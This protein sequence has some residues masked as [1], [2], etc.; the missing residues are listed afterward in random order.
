[1]SG[2]EARARA[3]A[4]DRAGFE[5]T[6][7]RAASRYDRTQ[8]GDAPGWAYWMPDP[9]DLAETGRALTMVGRP[10]QAIEALTPKVEAMAEYPRDVVLT[11]AY[12][13]EAHAAAGDRDRAVDYAAQA[14]AGLAA[15]IQSPRT[16]AVLAG[17]AANRG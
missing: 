11:Q 17:F 1:M 13:A 3:A 2:F 7:S 15:G 6:L 16:E 9:V 5:R 8:P 4:G 14:R 12:L 10:R